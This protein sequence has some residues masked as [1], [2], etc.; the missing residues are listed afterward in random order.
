MSTDAREA[1]RRLVATLE[2]H[3]E[4]VATRRG[5]ADAAVDD[6]YDSVASAFEQYEEALDTEYAET[7]PLVLDDDFEDGD[8]DGDLD[9]ELDPHAEEDE[10]ELDDD[11][12]D[13]DLR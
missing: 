8:G 10:D 11:V 7:L 5:P 9:E 3:L 4:A 12:E 6:A 13:F 1:L 2:E